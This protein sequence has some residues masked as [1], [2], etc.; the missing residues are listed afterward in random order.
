LKKLIWKN[1]KSDLEG[2]VWRTRIPF[3]GWLVLYTTDVLVCLNKEEGFKDGYE[4]R[5]TITFVPDPFYLW[6]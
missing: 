1:I 3:I 2:Y 5:N 4:W 6:K